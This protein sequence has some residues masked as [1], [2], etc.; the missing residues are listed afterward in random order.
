MLQTGIGRSKREGAYTLLLT[1]PFVVFSCAGYLPLV[2]DALKFHFGG[3]AAPIL[4]LDKQR[5]DELVFRDRFF[6]QNSDAFRLGEFLRY[7]P[8]HFVVSL[9][10]ELPPL[11]FFG[12]LFG[13][14]AVEE[15]L[16]IAA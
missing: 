6:V 10:F 1:Q 16:H 15:S 8:K 2:V 14:H 9:A 13:R 11:F 12:L 5:H 4:A 3:L 7:V